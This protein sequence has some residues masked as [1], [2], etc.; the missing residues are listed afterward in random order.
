MNKTLAKISI[1]ILFLLSFEEASALKWKLTIIQNGS[2]D[3]ITYEFSKTGLH[4]V[5]TPK[6]EHIQCVLNVKEP[7][8]EQEKAGSEK[9][10]LSVQ[11]AEVTCY[12]PLGGFA[13][14]KICSVP[15]TDED[16][17]VP[18]ILEVIEDATKFVSKADKTKPG[19]FNAYNILIN[20]E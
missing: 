10:S 20:C 18:V 16:R 3:K 4:K 7:I 2:D 19:K 17:S 8:K 11:L 13:G 14:K 15:S 1:A 12:H 5:E 9:V 6:L